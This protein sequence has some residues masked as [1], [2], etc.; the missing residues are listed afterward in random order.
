[1]ARCYVN[2][3]EDL[4]PQL[5]VLFERPNNPADDVIQADHFDLNVPVR[6]VGWVEA[7]QQHEGQAAFPAEG[8]ATIPAEGNE[9]VPAEENARGPAEGDVALPTNPVVTLF[10]S[11]A[12]SNSAGSMWRA[13]DEYY[14]SESDPDLV[15]PPPGVPRLTVKM[16]PHLAKNL[17]RPAALLPQA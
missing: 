1:M 5:C 7:P 12:S 4:W 6:D 8:N 17:P 13:L 3:Y 2:A 11:L 14:A 10:D 9:D 15:L 16:C